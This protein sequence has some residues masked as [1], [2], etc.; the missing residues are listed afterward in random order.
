M[1]LADLGDYWKLRG[2][3]EDPWSFVRRRKR[4]SSEP[5]Y[6][7]R[8]K[9]GGSIRLRNAPMDRHIFN[10][11]FARD[12][13]RLNPFAPGSLGTVL[14][15]GAHIGTFAVRVAPLAKRVICFEPM[16]DNF[17][18]LQQNVRRLAHVAVVNRAVGAERGTQTIYASANPSAHSMFP[19]EADRRGSPV[20][21]ETVTLADV[22]AEHAVETCDML[23]LDCEGAEYPILLGLAGEF[24]PRIRRIEME[25]HPVDGAAPEWSGRHL[26]GHL[27]KAGYK[28]DL[29][30][31]R[32]KEGKGHIFASR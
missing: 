30:P 21:V 17:A 24:W 18:L 19:A 2:L 7:V 22:F 16:P 6:D 32:H 3:I 29:I 5:H 13:Y 9:D 15:V 11:V 10:N 31:A 8:F 14:D 27:E 28:V 12:E 4:P 25:Y 26:A 20:Q 1:R 23:K